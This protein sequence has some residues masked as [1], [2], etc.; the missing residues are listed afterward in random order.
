MIY[1]NVLNIGPTGVRS[2]VDEFLGYRRGF[3]RRKTGA[4]LFM[5][6]NLTIEM[7]RDEK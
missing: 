7:S 2:I 6:I 4:L 5:R 3:Y 1:A